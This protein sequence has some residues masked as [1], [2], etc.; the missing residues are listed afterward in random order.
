MR[1]WD[2]DDGDACCTNLIAITDLDTGAEVDISVPPQAVTIK[3][4][5]V[6]AI[7]FS[8]NPLTFAVVFTN[9]F[10]SA[11]YAIA[12]TGEDSRL[13]T[14]FSKT[15]AGFTISANSGNTLTSEVGWIATLV[16]ETS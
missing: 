1:I 11:S 15:A 14:Y 9:P 10:P 3:A 12:L 13:F 6:S 2:L 16:G 8:G 4:G 7:S 5:L